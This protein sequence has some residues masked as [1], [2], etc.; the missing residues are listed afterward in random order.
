MQTKA[1][2]ENVPGSPA[3]LVDRQLEDARLHAVLLARLASRRRL[4]CERVLRHLLHLWPAARCQ[5]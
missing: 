1:A 4:L 5:A 3:D 2:D